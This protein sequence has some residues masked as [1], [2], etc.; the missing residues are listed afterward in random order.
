[1]RNIREYKKFISFFRLYKYEI[2]ALIVNLL[3]AFFSL[4]KF[5]VIPALFIV[6]L[7]F[8][9]S[10]SLIIYFKTKERDFYFLSLDKPGQEKDWVGRGIFKFVRNEKCFEITDSHV[11]YIFP[12]TLTWEDYIFESEFKIVNKYVAFIV[13]ANNLSNYL[14]LQITKEGINPHIRLNAQWI[15]KEFNDPQ[16]NL[17][18]EKK[19][20]PDT[21]YKVK[22]I[23]EKRSIRIILYKDTKPIFDRYWVI[24]NQMLLTLI[25][26]VKDG[27]KEKQTSKQYLQDVDFDFGAI[28]IRDHGEERGFV[29]NV[30]VEKL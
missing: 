13:R 26:V 5:S 15:R 23:C 7:V 21:W 17:E 8:T 25:E 4:S 20:T 6:I 24:P 9:V 28:G 12:K 2:I 11:G 3:V 18:F 19:L 22:I 14:M 1:M 16:V 10:T 29:K 27:E 30:F